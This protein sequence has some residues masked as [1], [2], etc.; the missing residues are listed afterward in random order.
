MPFFVVDLHT[1]GRVFNWGVR[2][3]RGGFGVQRPHGIPCPHC[4]VFGTECSTVGLPAPR[5]ECGIEDGL[6]TAAGQGVA[7]GSAVMPGMA[8]DP[9]TLVGSVVGVVKSS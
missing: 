7:C 2:E 6:A 4:A 3:R 8:A 5:A 9:V 1:F